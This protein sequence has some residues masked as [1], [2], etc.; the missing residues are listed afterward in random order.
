MSESKPE[1]VLPPIETGTE[2][3]RRLSARPIPA[4]RSFLA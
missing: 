1:P 4:W 2:D 3:A